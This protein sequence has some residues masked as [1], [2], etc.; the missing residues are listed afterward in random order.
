[1]DRPPQVGASLKVLRPEVDGIGVCMIYQVVQMISE[2]FFEMKL[3]NGDDANSIA[4]D[5][6]LC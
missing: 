3:R 4:V 5:D 2:V 1:M 6:D